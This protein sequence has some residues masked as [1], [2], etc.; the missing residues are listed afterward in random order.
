MDFLSSLVI[1]NAIQE[2]ASNENFSWLK[3]TLP[4]QF[5][6]SLGVMN[7]CDGRGGK[8]E[9]LSD[10]FRT[11]FTEVIGSIFENMNDFVALD[12]AA[13]Q[14]GKQFLFSRLRPVG[15]AAGSVDP[16]RRLSVTQLTGALTEADSIR[17]N[18]PDAARIIVEDDEEDV[19]DDILELHTDDPYSDGVVQVVHCF[20]ND[21]KSHAS[22]ESDACSSGVLRFPILYAPALEIILKSSPSIGIVISSLPLNTTEQ[23][24]TLAHILLKAGIVSKL[25]SENET[26]LIDS[27][28]GKLNRAALRKAKKQRKQGSSTYLH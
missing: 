23:K 1:P 21:I 3:R 22:F 24:V 15:V 5:Q 20:Q 10:S 16:P 27:G 25:Q 18:A 28:K 2:M 4:R 9:L 8:Q 7:N 26:N 12:A 6:D 19:E 13:D 11:A 14:V 17:V